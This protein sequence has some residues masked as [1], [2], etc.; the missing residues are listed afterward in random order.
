MGVYNVHGG[1]NRIVPGAGHYLDEVTE[2]RRITAGVIALL[3]ASGHTA[4]NCTDDVGKTVGANLANIVAKC[5]THSADLDISI[6]Q[7]AAR[8]DPGDGKTKGV[9]VFVYNTNSK[10]YAAAE[11]VCTKLA[12]LGFTNRGVKTSTGLYVLKH[13]NSPAMLI[14]VGFVDD[15]DDADLYNKVGVNA[16]CKAIVEGILN[17]STTSTPTL[18]PAA[19]PALE[20][21]PSYG[22]GEPVFRKN[23]ETLDIG[24]NFSLPTKEGRFKWLLY[25]LQKQEWS[26][27]VEWTAS[28]WITLAIDKAQ[29][30]VQCKLYNLNSKLVDTKTIGTDAGTGTVI[31]GT[32][33]GWRGKEI[34]IGCTSNNPDVKF[35]MKLYNT[36]TKQWFAQFS[37]QWASFTP[38][39][40]THYVVR[41][42]AYKDGRLLDY[43]AV[44]I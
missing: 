17:S 34:L 39:T 37:G 32:Y 21:E 25:D 12:A 43:R 41:Y 13:T 42:E 19:P 7:N 18:T 10:A 27:L 3:Q 4:H 40:D 30:L 33:A 44:G 15:K 2:D 9:E 16:I 23:K 22:L 28:N 1:H 35:K 5:N 26:T 20:N 24:F 31:T 11:R 36:K 29:Y 14:E 6:H 8:V 38:D